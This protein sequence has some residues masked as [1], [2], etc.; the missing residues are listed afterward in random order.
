MGEQS[1]HNLYADSR[2]CPCPDVGTEDYRSDSAVERETG[3]NEYCLQWVPD[4]HLHSRV[5]REFEPNSDIKYVYI[6]S[7]IAVFL[8][9]IV[10][11]NYMNLSTA[12][13]FYRAREVGIRKVNGANRGQIAVQSIGE[14]VLFSMNGLVVSLLL[15][16]FLLPSFG[17]FVERDLHFGLINSFEIVGGFTILAMLIGLISGSY[18]ALI[19]SRLHPI[20][21]LKRARISAANKTT[22]FRNTLVV[23]QFV[24]SIAM[25]VGTLVLY[26]QLHFLKHR[27]LGFQKE[28]I[29]HIYAYEP[30]FRGRYDAFRN[31]LL[32]HPGISGVTYTSSTLAY[33]T[34]GG[35][36]WWE[37]KQEDEDINFY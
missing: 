17:I 19:L 14:S 26:K 23:I 21:V 10:S 25:I 28:N 34:N 30:E 24:I 13:A 4:I 37:G 5:N 9:L 1:L 32:Q 29:V 16:M 33:N 11:F 18:P 36:A 27:D 22:G 6:F 35:G 3:E 7:A 12:Q 8:L 31:E 2:G 15:V 20:N